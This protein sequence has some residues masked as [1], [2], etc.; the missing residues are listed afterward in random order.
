MRMPY[1]PTTTAHNSIH[2][3]SFKKKE[4]RTDFPIRIGEISNFFEN[5]PSKPLDGQPGLG[6]CK[7]NIFESQLAA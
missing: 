3:F 4:S 7:E 5:S 1:L 6:Q 2:F